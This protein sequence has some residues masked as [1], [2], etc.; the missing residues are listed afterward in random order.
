MKTGFS[1]FVCAAIF[2]IVIAL[3]YW[4]SSGEYAGIAL[5]TLMGLAMFFAAGYVLFAEREAHLAADQPD[6]VPADA[7]GENLGTFTLFTPWPALAAFGSVLGVV[8]LAIFWPLS[9]L[10]GGILALSLSLLARERM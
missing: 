4:L 7:A 6:A 3:V 5:L 2:G 1:V 8:G 9:V 10:G